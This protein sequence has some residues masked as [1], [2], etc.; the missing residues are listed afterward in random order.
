MRDRLAREFHPLFSVRGAPGTHDVQSSLC[1]IE[2]LRHAGPGEKTLIPKF[3]KALDEPSAPSD[4]KYFTGRPDLIILEGWCVGVPP[5]SDADLLVPVNDLERIKDSEGVWRRRA[6]KLLA[7]EYA[8]LFRKLN[9]QI[10]LVAPSFAKVVEWRQL[11]EKKLRS[12]R[13]RTGAVMTDDEVAA[14]TQFFERLTVWSQESMPEFSDIVL[15][16]DDLHRWTQLR[17]WVNEPDGR[18]RLIHLE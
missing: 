7:E 15:V 9:F 1:L 14:F 8:E 11:Q 13:G 4:C 18:K 2:K 12:K 3:D 16:L 6:N 17:I 10:S 5:Q